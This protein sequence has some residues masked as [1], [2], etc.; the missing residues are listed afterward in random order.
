MTALFVSVGDAYLTPPGADPVRDRSHGMDGLQEFLE[1]VRDAGIA[2]GHLRGLF[3]ILIGR[4]ISTTSGN[5]V[6]TGVTWRELSTMLKNV[7]FDK[8]L[9]RELGAD[10]DT[11]SP[12]DRQRMW[13]SAISLA[14]VDSPQALAQATKLATLLKPLGYLVGP[15]PPG[16]MVAAPEPPAKPSSPAKEEDDAKG[17]KKKK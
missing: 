13:Y 4:R 17:K 9:V 7:R 6:S 3:H 5:V 12:R 1:A 11:L 14:K 16:V 2:S 8:E 10:P 15:T